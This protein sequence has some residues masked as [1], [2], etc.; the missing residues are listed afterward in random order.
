MS[1]YVNCPA[2]HGKGVIPLEEARRIEAHQMVTRDEQA[3]ERQ[4]ERAEQDR[5]EI[6]YRIKVSRERHARQLAAITA[7]S[8]ETSPEQV[9]E[10]R[11][12]LAKLEAKRAD[13]ER[14]PS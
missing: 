3:A 9:A 7:G 13:E 4:R 10:L 5:A 2:C 11:A 8:P 1:D 6:E 12:R 14:E